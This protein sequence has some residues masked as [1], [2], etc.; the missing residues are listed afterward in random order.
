MEFAKRAYGSLRGKPV[1][2]AA[3]LVLVPSA[4]GILV[5]RLLSGGSEGDKDLSKALFVA[6]V[7]LI[8]GGLLGGLLKIVFGELALIRQRR[9][10][11]VTF[12][13][14]VLT[15]LKSVHDRVGRVRILIPAHRSAKTYGQEMRD[16]IDAR[17][18]LKNVVRAMKLGVSGLRESTLRSVHEEVMTM[19]EY[20]GGLT[21]EFQENYTRLSKLQ[22]IYEAG[23]DAKLKTQT[24]LSGEEAMS[25]HEE[26]VWNELKGLEKLRGLIDRC[27]KSPYMNR[28][29]Q[30]LNRASDTL[31]RELQRIHAGH[32]NLQSSQTAEN[33]E[34]EDDADESG[35]AGE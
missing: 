24:G 8:Y 30:P 6:S 13:S 21:D 3:L 26:E 29:E 17:V 19:E 16:L 12:I 4:I 20:L 25:D 27:D 23:V 1:C 11:Q 35:E 7:T 10:A 32:G 14:N 15:N 9:E 34:E 31:R 28:F 22:R 2:S 33:R 18:T 5:A